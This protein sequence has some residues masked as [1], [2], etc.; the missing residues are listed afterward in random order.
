[1]PGSSSVASQISPSDRS[2]SLPTATKPANAIPRALPRENSE[3]IMPP[4]CEATKM[5]P[6]R[7]SGSSKVG[8]PVSIARLRR[9]ITP[10]LDGPTSRMPVSATIARS[11]ASRATPSGPASAKPSA[12]T[13]AIF[14][15]RLPHSATA[16]T[17]CSVPVTM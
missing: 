11:R 3:P 8:L 4:E 9:S 16:S 12:S 1:M 6:A 5:R 2:T 10:Q 15:P 7:M 13:V 14:T 17:A